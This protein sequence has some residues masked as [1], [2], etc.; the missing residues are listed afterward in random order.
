[1]RRLLT[2]AL[3][4]LAASCGDSIPTEIEDV[5]GSYQLESVNGQK[6]PWYNTMAGAEV[7]SGE[8]A[9]RADGTYLN[10]TWLKLT[11]PNPIVP[12]LK[13]AGTY[14][15]TGPGVIEFWE[16]GGMIAGDA[17]G[18][19]VTIRYGPELNYRYRRQ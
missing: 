3:F 18:S 13:T 5:A 11:N 2:A 9:L 17:A 14:S 7:L 1:V 8:L 19:Y 4:A 12:Y 15:L 16:N 6:L 10:T